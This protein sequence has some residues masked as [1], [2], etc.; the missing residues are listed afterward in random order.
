MHQEPYDAKV[1]HCCGAFT[2]KEDAE[3]CRE[4]SETTEDQC[5]YGWS[6]YLVCVCVDPADA[7]YEVDLEDNFSPDC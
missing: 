4:L 5:S 7:T 3:L 1:P 6:Y 2:K